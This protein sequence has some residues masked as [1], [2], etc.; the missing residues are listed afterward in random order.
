MENTALTLF[1]GFLAQGFF[2]A[3]TIVQ[4]IMS[5]R[6][7]Q[8]LSPSIFWVFSLAGAYLLCIYGWMRGDFA[9][10]FGQFLSYYIYLWNLN[11]KDIWR[12]LPLPLRLVLLLTPVVAIC[13]VASNA[14][15]F[16]DRF[17]H[18]DGVPLGLLIFGSAGQM[19]FTL[20]FVYQ[21]I[22]SHGKGESQLPAG[23]WL[24]SLI[25][26]LCIISYGIIRY[27]VVLMVGQSSG[28]AIYTRN[29]VLIHKGKKD[30]QQKTNE[31][32]DN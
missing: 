6:A 2:S 20:R 9:I 13:F 29:L 18:N 25:G 12:Q 11:A 4:W 3:R 26:S 27:D 21:W 10:V 5:E 24:I 1:I 17:L 28:I 8:V 16:A 19:L 23:F 15:A 30:T 31:N 32:L 14:G 7:R 22:Y